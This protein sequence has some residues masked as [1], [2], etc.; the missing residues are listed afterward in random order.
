MAKEERADRAKLKR[1][2]TEL[3][4]LTE[5]HGIKI[6]G[7]GECGSPWVIPNNPKYRGEN[8]VEHLHY[9]NTHKAYGPYDEHRDC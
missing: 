5:R 3:N 2:L 4:E 8:L 6:G 7:C 9:C 1:F